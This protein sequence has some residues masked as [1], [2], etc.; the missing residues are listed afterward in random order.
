INW[1]EKKQ[2][3]KAT[4]TASGKKRL[5]GVRGLQGGLRGSQSPLAPCKN[6]Y[7]FDSFFKITVEAKPIL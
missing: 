4:L 3:K 7:K 2:L 1:F 5:K 6:K